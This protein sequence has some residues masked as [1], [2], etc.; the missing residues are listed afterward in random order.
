MDAFHALLAEEVPLRLFAVIGLGYALGRLTIGG[1]SLGVAAVLFV[2]LAM[3][4]WDPERF[5]I[6]PIVPTI[7]LA[8]FVYTIGLASGPGV[9][10]ALTSRDGMRL[11]ALTAV[12]LLAAALMTAGLIRLVGLKPTEAAGLFC[13]GLTNTPALAAQLELLERRAE[14]TPGIDVEGP[15]VGYSLAYPFGVLGLFM[16][17]ALITRW[18]GI[19]PHQEVESYAQ[20]TGSARGPVF[21]RNYRITRLK[22]N[23]NQLEAEWV[24]ARTGLVVS[25][26]LHEGKL[27]RVAPED[28]LA[29]GDLV[30]AVGTAEMHEKGRPLLGEPAPDKNLEAFQGDVVFRRFFVS[31]RE[32]VGKNLEELDLEAALQATVTRV[33]RGDVEMPAGPGL[34]LSEGDIVMVVTR[35]ENVPAVER[36]FGDSLERIAHT[37]YLS[38]SLGMVLGVL[39]GNVPIPL[40][41]PP[42]PE[43]GVAG[44]CLLVALVLGKL[45]RTGSI[46]WNLSL[47]ANLALREMGLLFFL[48]S[49]GIRA[50]GEFAEAMAHEGLV[51]L[52]CGALITLTSVAVLAIGG[53]VFLKQN[54]VTLLGLI[55]G[56]HTQPACLAYA[57]TL[58]KSDGVNIGYAAVFPVAMILKVLLA[59]A[60][61]SLF[62]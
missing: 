25:R 31:R 45:Q 55:S 13:G 11:N 37:D 41:Q 39:L 40:G 27:D 49:V 38:V 43:L 53:R 48:A 16:A 1:F 18:P 23:G 14:S 60:L 52:A 15:V 56:V 46:V 62:L 7:G 28:V 24:R 5:A 30:V 61:L 59:T 17:L 12:A 19:D 26:R 8:L 33:R 51:L 9:F 29:I 4:A 35:V 3:G 50:G 22:P 34:R 32:L 47:E 36:F 57:N 2:G 21:S 42:Y 10:R 6:P 44:G 54:L 58:V 20:Q